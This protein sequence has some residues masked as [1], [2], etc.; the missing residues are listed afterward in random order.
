[1][2]LYTFRCHNEGC[3]GFCEIH[4]KMGDTTPPQCPICEKT[5]QISIQPSNI[6]V[7]GGTPKFHR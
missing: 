3:K 7:S 4:R 1:M 5:M 2:P 6:N